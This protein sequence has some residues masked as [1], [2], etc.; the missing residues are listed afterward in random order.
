MTSDKKSQP[1]VLIIIPNLGRGGAQKV[2]HQQLD[3]LSKE[4]DVTA[5]VF[6]WEGAFDFDHKDNIISL[7][8]SGGKNVIQKIKNFF[9]RVI[10]LK[11]IK[12][13]L[14][15]AVSISHLEGADYINLLSKK[16]EKVICWIHGSKFHDANINGWIGFIRKKFL[17]P[18]LYSRADRIITVSK[19]ISEELSYTIPAL[20]NRIETI[21]NGFD[22]EDIL[23]LS[24]EPI[25]Q[26]FQS[27]FEHK[28]VIITHCRLSRQKNLEAL[29]GI[30]SKLDSRKHT[31]LLIVG[32]GELRDALLNRCKESGLTVWSVW[33]EEPIDLS[34]EVFFLG[35][36]SNPFNFLRHSSLYVMTSGWEGFPLALCEAMICGLPV[37]ASDCFTGPRE[38]IAPEI[39]LPQPIQSP[40]STSFG[41]LMP[42]A[43]LSKVTSLEIWRFQIDKL[44]FKNK[45][46]VSFDMDM[47][48]RISEF[49]LSG[50]MNKSK[51]LINDIDSTH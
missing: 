12:K 50:T 21:Y 4:F 41:V 9:L 40:F 49:A 32:D 44:L 10:R 24:Y 27:L 47:R 33:Y 31:R 7:D 29:L 17:M 43:E 51:K 48:N 34:R 42:L 18:Y 6:N 3:F 28:K 22:M 39:K 15:I 2:F 20:K 30:F 23:S 35:Q 36:R 25:D 26:A 16:S 45:D 46:D 19:G 14:N 1:K 38:I 37:I 5:C 11:R 8:V 13:R